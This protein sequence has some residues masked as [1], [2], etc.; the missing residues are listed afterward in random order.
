MKLVRYPYKELLILYLLPG[1]ISQP[2]V[3]LFLSISV[4]Q[5]IIDISTPLLAL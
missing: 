4:Y 3:A 1:S 5:I 2:H